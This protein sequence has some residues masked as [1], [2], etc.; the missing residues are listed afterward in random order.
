MNRVIA[1]V[2]FI[3]SM[4]VGMLIDMAMINL[5]VEIINP[6][7]ATEVALLLWIIVL[8]ITILPIIYVSGFIATIIT[9]L[10]TK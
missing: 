10:I 1:I 9:I 3:L 5:L 7:H 8:Y 4:I 2:I 6:T